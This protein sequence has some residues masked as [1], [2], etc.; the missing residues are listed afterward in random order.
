MKQKFDDRNIRKLF[1]NLKNVENDYPA[2]M[3][4]SRRNLYIR[5]A[6]A[7]TVVLRTTGDKTGVTVKGAAGIGVR[8]SKRPPR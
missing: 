4:R 7:M 3:M 6:A 5:Q 2:R 8:R 1:S